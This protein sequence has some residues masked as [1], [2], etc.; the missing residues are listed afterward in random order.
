LIAAIDTTIRALH[1][2]AAAIWAGGL[3]FLALAV[4]VARKTVPER[5]RIELFRGLGRR[6]LLVGGIALAVL[7]VTGIDMA[8]DYIPSW[9]DLGAT[10]FGRTLRDKLGLVAL[11]IVLTLFHSLVQGPAIRRLREQ[12][13]ERPDDAE[14]AARIRRKSAINGVIQMVILIATLAILVLAAKLVTG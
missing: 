1:L 8:D 3:V 9:S 14:L 5:E 13:L 11:V 6:F 7:V 2:I 10:Q 12:A 4:G